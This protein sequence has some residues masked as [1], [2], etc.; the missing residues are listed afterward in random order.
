MAAKTNLNIP[1][2]DSIGSWVVGTLIAGIFFRAVEL[3]ARS[4]LSRLK[5][6]DIFVLRIPSEHGFYTRKGKLRLPP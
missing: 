5:G 1:I 3:I 2:P 4:I 6:F